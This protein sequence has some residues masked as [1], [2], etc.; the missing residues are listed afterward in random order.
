MGG[1]CGTVKMRKS[2]PA[3]QAG[4]LFAMRYPDLRSPTRFSLGCH[5]AGFQPRG[6][7]E[8]HPFFP[9]ICSGETSTDSVVLNVSPLPSMERKKH[10]L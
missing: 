10:E 8:L 5:M 9:Y 7:C 3:L 6:M 1:T 2:V 4:E